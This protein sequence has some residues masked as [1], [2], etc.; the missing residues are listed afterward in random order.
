[1][2]GLNRGLFEALLTNE[3]DS[4]LEAL[5]RTLTA[6]VSALH[7][8]EAADRLALHISRH[9]Q[10]TVGAMDQQR[11]VQLGVALA[12]R[13]INLLQADSSGDVDVGDEPHPSASVL[14]SVLAKMP[15]GTP[16]TLQLPATPL[17]D[18]TL[19]TNAPGEPRLQHQIQ[20]EI[21]SSD[22]IDVLMAFVR[23]TGIRTLL[24]SVRRHADAGRRIRVLTTTYTGSTELE[25]LEKLEAAGAEIRV[26]Y[27]TS[28]TRLHAKAWLFHRDSGY[29]TAFIGSSNLTHSA[30]VTGLEWNVRVSGARNP[31]VIDKFSAVFESYWASD[32]FRPF[33]ADEF[34]SRTA[35]N[36]T[37]HTILLSPVEIRPEPFQSRLLEQIAIARIQG[38]HRNLL[39]SATGT[40][41]TVMAALDYQRLKNTL[42]RSRLLFVAH[43][44]EILEQS[45]ATFR[46]AL[47]DASFGELWVGGSRPSD[48]EHVFASIQSLASSGVSLIDA[49]HF[50]VVIVDEFHH[51]AAESYRT[52]LSHLDPKELLG[53]TA[54]PERSDGASILDWFGGRIAAELRLWDAIEQHRLCP[55]SYFGVADTN[56]LSGVTWRRG[57]G[58]AVDELT[59]VLTADDA[60]ARLV[61]QQ[62]TRIVP[63]ARSMRALGFCVSVR[64]AQF[65]ARHFQAAGINAVAVSAESSPEERANALAQLKA[66][67]IQA[68]FSVDLFNEG[69]DIPSVDTLILLR[70]TESPIV[71]L[72]QLGRG[73]RKEAGKATCTVLDFVAQHRQEFRFD[74]RLGALLPGGRKRLIEQ[75]EQ[76]FP[77]LPSGCDMQL[78]PVARDRIL[79]SLKS[80]IPNQWRQKVAEAQRVREPGN[81]LSLRRFIEE[82]GIPLEEIY[83]NE[84]CWSEL[85]EDAGMPTLPSGPHESVIRKAI[86]RIL[87]INDIERPDEFAK[88]LEGNAYISFDQ[89]SRKERRLA[90]MLTAV[91]LESITPQPE[92]VEQALRALHAHPQIVSELKELLRLL[93]DRVDHLQVGLVSHPETPLLVHARY[94]RR[95]ILASFSDGRS[96]RLPPWREG[97]RWI[98]RESVDLLASTFDKSGERFSP[99]TR[100]RDYAVSRSLVHWESQSTTRS[101]SETGLRYQEHESRGS[102]VL[103]FARLSPGERAFWLLG[104]GRYQSHIGDRPMAIHWKLDVELPGDLF[105]AFAAAVS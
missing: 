78:D 55:F 20:T 59:N 60:K 53:L 48:F 27:D 70:P 91:L 66:G 33:N 58:Y 105:A 31:D 15:D 16:E 49:S 76:G 11:R 86:G 52:L 85:L 38:R 39:V 82:S 42:P 62:L 71:F 45:R 50:D 26:S 36:S 92:T 81:E 90:H 56:D 34:R 6:E 79:T 13:I 17:L 64:H 54:T 8:A 61:I 10:R 4:K 100:Y 40:G 67:S 24:D 94:S 69:I 65:M 2:N 99:T 41:K 37:A 1:M 12:T 98:E 51:A 72:Q 5:D 75:V 83:S 80:S 96:F 93:K 102:T 46:H 29:S 23:Q 63:N 87:H 18:T 103:L 14:R 7:H 77:Y 9:L 35:Q 19:L 95:E 73:L 57:V 25:A 28:S 88:L 97:V 84:H 44:K 3:L 89:K 104:P 47:R 21:P 43:R 101:T 32:D 74:R 68:V 22:R 30:Q